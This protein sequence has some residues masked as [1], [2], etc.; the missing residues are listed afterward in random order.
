[1]L[2]R[3]SERCVRYLH[4]VRASPSAGPESVVDSVL[5]AN[6]SVL[7]AN[8]ST[9]AFF[10]ASL[11]A[12]QN[13]THRR[14][15]TIGNSDSEFREA[16]PTP[17]SQ[18]HQ[19]VILKLGG[20]QILSTTSQSFIRNDNRAN[21]VYYSNTSPREAGLCASLIT[22][23]R[24]LKI[25]QL[26]E[27]QGA[28]VPLLI[29]GKH[30]IAHAETGTGKSFG[31]ALAVANKIL[32]D[33]VSYRMHTIIFTPTEELALQ[34]DRW[35]KHF[36][37]C[38]SQICQPALMSIPLEVQLTKLHNIQPH[39]LVGTPQR[40]SQL[41]D[42]APHIFGH[43]L[44]KQVDTIILDEGDLVLSAK[45]MSNGRESTGEDLINRLYRSNAGEVPAQIVVA[46][47]TVDGPTAQKVNA[48][49]RNDTAMRLTTSFAE[50]SIPETIQFYFV[51]GTGRPDTAAGSTSS[52][53]D[54]S[55]LQKTL[56][57][58]CKHHVD[59][60]ILVFTSHST[61]AV[62]DAINASMGAIL[63]TQRKRERSRSIPIAGALSH[64]RDS[65]PLK[66]EAKGKHNNKPMDHHLRKSEIHAENADISLKNDTNISRLS[67]G[68]LLVGVGSFS[69]SRGMHIGH[70]S[71]VVL[72]GETPNS[73]EFVHCAGRTGRMGSEGEVFV[74][75]PPPSGRM[76]QTICQGLEI[77]FH[78]TRRSV[79]DRLLGMDDFFEEDA[80]RVNDRE[81]AE[82]L[83]KVA[84][85][86]AEVRDNLSSLL[87]EGGDDAAAAPSGS[88]NEEDQPLTLHLDD[89]VESAKLAKHRDAVSDV[90]DEQYSN[91]L[92]YIP[93]HKQGYL[94]EL[95]SEPTPEE[96][97]DERRQANRHH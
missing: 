53:A 5:S 50:H 10:E 29:K 65:T 74:L 64:R 84:A 45:I 41:A 35:L 32:R 68:R 15:V 26:T 70:V 11:Y 78:I 61:E 49:M 79:I 14:G 8:S 38:A 39:V 30:I 44:R 27:L 95:W 28:L 90:L 60:K 72:F 94:R 96:E 7:N 89:E 20:A 66:K 88:W 59:P 93:I 37:G 63:S 46:S 17:L 62:A 16:F 83:G 67:D 23:L 18:R 22:S 71:H 19:E 87:E 3:S 80:K 31:I 85:E 92:A 25:Y 42:A 47:A 43:R 77:P 40:I 73:A 54:F 58:I 34:Y 21:P 51:S 9:K 91:P 6:K 52:I 75:F 76:C 36:G 12:G 81:R 69:V 57:L 97:E 55:L 24:K 1:M 33:S 13:S 56:Q 2:R 86:E 48:W 82:R 4:G